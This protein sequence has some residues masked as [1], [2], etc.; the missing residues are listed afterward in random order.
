[1]DEPKPINLNNF[2][3]K[4]IIYFYSKYQVVAY[5]QTKWFDDS[6]R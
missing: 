1:M 3:I 5:H 6:N 2:I 4:K